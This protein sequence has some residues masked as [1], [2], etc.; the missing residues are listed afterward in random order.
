MK[1]DRVPQR[2]A[3]LVTLSVTEN[4]IGSMNRDEF[5][6]Y[7]GGLRLNLSVTPPTAMVSP[8]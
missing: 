6:D 7:S 1:S 5:V 2:V 8:N 4:D 3:G